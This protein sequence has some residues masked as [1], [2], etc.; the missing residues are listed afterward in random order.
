MKFDFD[1]KKAKAK[2]DAMTRDHMRKRDKFI[3][4]HGPENPTKIDMWMMRMAYDASIRTTTT[5]AKRL[6]EMGIVFPP[7][8]AVADTEL[9]QACAAVARI[10]EF[11]GIYVMDTDH[12]DDRRFYSYITE[13]MMHDENPDIPP[14]PGAH[15]SISMLGVPPAEG[16]LIDELDDD[17]EPVRWPK[18]ASRDATLPQSPSA[19]AAVIGIVLPNQSA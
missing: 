3:A 2:R 6:A 14:A 1:M 11:I 15:C 7:S 12:L 13:T 10:L 5:D 19:T 16:A 18:V 9:P 8:S 17:G 4:I